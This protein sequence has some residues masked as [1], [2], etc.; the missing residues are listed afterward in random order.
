M[1]DNKSLDEFDPSVDE[2]V[3]ELLKLR[4]SLLQPGEGVNSHPDGSQTAAR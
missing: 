4:F 1:D 3:T 2:F